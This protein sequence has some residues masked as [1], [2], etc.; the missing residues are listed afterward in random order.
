MSSKPAV[1]HHPI[2]VAYLTLGL[3]ILSLPILVTGK[4]LSLV[5]L[6]R[7]LLDKAGQLWLLLPKI[8]SNK[9]SPSIKCLNHNQDHHHHSS[10][11]LVAIPSLL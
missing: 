9:A 8:S 3:P 7:T 11:H 1:D 6:W 2:W 4:E 5:V 10:K